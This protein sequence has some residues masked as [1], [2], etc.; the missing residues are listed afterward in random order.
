MEEERH[1][2]SSNLKIIKRNGKNYI[3]INE[4]LFSGKRN[5]NWNSVELYL[6]KYIRKSYVIKESGDRIYINSDF[7]DEYT[8]SNYSKNSFGAIRKAKANV[9]QIIP[10]L[11]MYA[12]EISYQDNK[13]EKHNKDAKNGWLRCTVRFV[14]PI[15][16]DKKQKIGEN[17]FRA[18]MIIRCDSNNKKYLYD[19][20][21]IKKE[22]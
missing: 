15:T 11:I 9:S 17:Y 2:N 10:E 5:I 16:N 4:I 1:M 22:T 12:T 18:R 21:D 14:L 19:I 20:I 13:K 3:V 7:P 6:K 8:N